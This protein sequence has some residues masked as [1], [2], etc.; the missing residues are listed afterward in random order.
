VITE[1]PRGVQGLK[2]ASTPPAVCVD[3][4]NDAVLRDAEGSDDVR[5]TAC[6]LADQLSGKHPEGAMVALGVLENWLDAAEVDPSAMIAYHADRT[7]DPPG[8][9]GNER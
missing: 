2:D 6:S 3:T 1:L 4:T 5:L 8:T 9:V 7:A